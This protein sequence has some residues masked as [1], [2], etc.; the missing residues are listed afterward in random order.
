VLSTVALIN[1]SPRSP[2]RDEI[3]QTLDAI[4]DW[5]PP[6]D[7]AGL[8][9]AEAYFRNVVG[10]RVSGGDG[11]QR[12][13]HQAEEVTRQT[14]VVD[15]RAVPLVSASTRADMDSKEPADSEI[16]LRSRAQGILAFTTILIVCASGIAQVSAQV[17]IW[18]TVAG[19]CVLSMSNHSVTRQAL[20]GGDTVIGTLVLSSVLNAATTS[21][22]ALIVGRGIGW[23]WGV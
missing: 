12:P 18:A 4:P 9:E 6:D 21:A 22:A 10:H 1:S 23:V 13:G 2:T 14:V 17:S 5:S 16:Q 8:A 11:L 19:S 15:R 20:G 7:F 3:A